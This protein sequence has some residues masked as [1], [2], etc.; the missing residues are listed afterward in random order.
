MQSLFR[1]V[2]GFWSAVF[3]R[4]TPPWHGV[5]KIVSGT[6]VVAKDRV[7]GVSRQS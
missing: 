7:A 4:S 5:P 2:P 1:S 6:N 3:I